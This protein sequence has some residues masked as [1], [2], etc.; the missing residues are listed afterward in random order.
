MKDS[1][2]REINYLRISVTDLCN[3]RCQY[4]M[5]DTGICKVEHKDILSFEEFY[6]I[7]K[8]LVELGITKVR[9]TGGEPLIKRD[10]VDFVKKIR[11]LKGIEEISM[12]TNGILLEDYAEGLKKAGLD[13]LNIS[14]DTLDRDKYREI[15]RNGDIEKVFRG[16]E[17]AKSVGLGPIKI[18]T[19]LIDGFNTDEIED[20][21]ELTRDQDIDV[22]FIELMPIGEVLK[23]KDKG[24]ISGDVILEKVKELKEVKREDPSSPAK[25][26]KLEG[27]K[28]KVGIISPVTCK[29]CS[30]CNRIRLTSRGKIKLCLHSNEELDLK[31]YLEDYDKLKEFLKE[32]IMAKPKEHHL[33]EGEY[34]STS[35]SKIGG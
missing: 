2:G 26:Y 22:R 20:L 8:A 5:P 10:I 6:T 29:F 32:S 18:N 21:V 27:G 12:T 33:E 35:M 11:S 16:I 1:Y 14:L 9:I 34:V 7:T 3:L 25:Y 19:V 24:T 17:K 15:T 4:C 28:G 31:P 30:D 13:R 23:L